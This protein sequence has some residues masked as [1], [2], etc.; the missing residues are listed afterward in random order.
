MMMNP[1]KYYPFGYGT[2]ETNSLLD[3]M[4]MER[5]LELQQHE[6]R[7][8]ELQWAQAHPMMML[9]ELN[10]EASST[11][12][13]AM[14]DTM[15]QEATIAPPTEEP[16]APLRPTAPPTID[17]AYRPSRR[18]PKQPVCPRPLVSRAISPKQKYTIWE[19]VYLK[20]RT[21]VVAS[22]VAKVSRSTAHKYTWM[23][24]GNPPMAEIALY[25][26]QVHAQ[27]LQQIQKK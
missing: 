25:N 20:K 17:L 1:R 26:P 15:Q 6:D 23:F 21:S 11:D 18:Q 10:I 22:R 3:L 4:H 9:D 19:T 2:Q 16:N 7:A 24:D 12:T 5:D 27:L 14:Q 13:D 8:A